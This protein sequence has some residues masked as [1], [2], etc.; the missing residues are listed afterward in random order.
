MADIVLFTPLV[1]LDAAA[2]LQGFIDMCRDK[3][4]VFGANLP[5]QDNVWDVTDSVAIKG[6][7][8]KRERITFSNA[9]TVGTN[10]QEIMREPFLSFAKAYLRYMH[11]MRPT[12]VIHNRVAALRA[13]E[14]ALSE[15]GEAL[16]PIRIDSHILNRAAQIVV[17][18]FSDGAAYRV[19]GQIEL[20]AAF[21]AEN[22]LLAIPVRWRNPV[23]RP[24]TAV[25]VGKEFD[26]RRAKK[27]PSSA[28]LEA[29]PQIFR[30][31]VEPVDVITA[32]VAAVLL[33][34]PDRIGEV[35]SLPEC[36]EVHEPRKG[37]G[38]AYG[39]RWWPAKGAEPMVK[40]LVPSLA[41]VVKDA[42][43]KIRSVT[44]EARRI[45]KW[46]EQYPHQIYLTN[47][48][49]HLRGRDWL[50]LA[51]IA[52]IMG[53][54]QGNA[55]R[56]WC[57]AE[58]IKLE[59]R[60]GLGKLA[61]ARFLDVE[62]S[63][64]G[65]LPSGFPVFD[66]TTGLKYSDA[67]FIMR[68]NELGAQ[69]GTYRCMIEPIGIGQI[70]TG[71]GSRSNFGF[72]SVFDRFSFVEPDGSPIVVTSHQ[73]RH[74]LNTLAQAGGLSQL[75]IAKWSGR[76][77]VRQNEAYDHVTPEQMLQKIR[78]AVGEEQMFSSLAELPKK[79]M[80]RRDEFARL[81]IP[82]AH[83]TDLGYCIH[84]YTASPCQ[85]H[86]D[87]INCQDLVCVKGDVRKTAMLRRR[88]AES[89]D[90]LCKAETAREDGYSG[91]DRWIEHHRSTV[92]RYSKLNS[93]MEDPTVPEGAV[94]QLA[95][96]IA[97]TRIKREKVRR[98]PAQTDDTQVDLP[99]E[100]R[101]LMEE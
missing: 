26:E 34:A 4:T 94:I 58:G 75:D 88:L 25:R 96:P 33:A 24:G 72:Q 44:E 31:A 82:T 38:D 87:C 86:L 29:L 99:A 101:A 20:L 5:F 89:R 39:L 77:D 73:F 8:N 46:Y 48:V 47:D 62:R 67:L 37:G 12:K 65:M 16:S 3:L 59:R 57:K 36:C 51:E 27:M 28:A 84:D 17:D 76:R 35:L 79:V 42:L 81:V 60:H 70:N 69:R 9:A 7:G 45:A 11:G 41:T 54:R 56:S 61:F 85:L 91:S 83:T 74:Y 32:S 30:A 21:M 63:V 90:L 78:G 100:I 49:S 66:K 92:E 52:E 98:L 50:S 2:N 43:R 6:R 1:E 18:R 40:W 64:L 19:A 80:I 10:A 14:A 23:K 71:L 53:F 93:I 68:R 22:R 95:P 97:P 55:A 15:R 13:I